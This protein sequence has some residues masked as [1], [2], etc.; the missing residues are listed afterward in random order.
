MNNDKEKMNND[1]E[2]MNKDKERMNK[3]MMED[4]DRLT[5]GKRKHSW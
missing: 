3:D 4:I 5:K 2:K 1:K